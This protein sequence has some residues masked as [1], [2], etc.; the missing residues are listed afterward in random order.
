MVG[1]MWMIHWLNK[2]INILIIMVLQNDWS[3]VNEFRR[4]IDVEEAKWQYGC[5]L[6]MKSIFT[7][8]FSVVKLQNIFI[9]SLLYV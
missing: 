9:F 2:L 6:M 3:T 7:L 1:S 4:E 5:Y 8:F